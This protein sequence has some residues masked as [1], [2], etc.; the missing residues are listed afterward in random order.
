MRGCVAAAGFR[1]LGTVT[2]L[3]GVDARDI[4][5]PVTTA[6]PLERPAVVVTFRERGRA[7]RVLAGRAIGW[8]GEHVNVSVSV[9]G[10]T[11]VVWVKAEDVA[12][13]P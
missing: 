13:A 6:P 3:R 11:H 10:M 8:T 2:D 9:D 7:H 1:T 12:R 5:G 4:R